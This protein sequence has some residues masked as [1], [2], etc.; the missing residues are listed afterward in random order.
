MNIETF[1]KFMTWVKQLPEGEYVYRGVSN[2]KY[3]IEASTYR[4]LKDKNGNFRYE[5]D[6]S[7][8]RLL[9]INK[10]IIEDGNRHRHG[11][12]NE[13]PLS[14]LNLL[15]ELQHRGA[16]TCLIDFTKNPLVALW[17]ACRDSSRGSVD[18]KV[19]A[20]DIQS[21]FTFKR[22]T[23]EEAQKSK[24]DLFFQRDDEEGYQLYQWQ[25][26]Y[27]NSRMRAQQSIFL[28]GG[29]WQAIKPSK[30]C[31]IKESSK[32]EIRDSLK[33]LSGITGHILFPDF[34]GF[35]E[36]HAESK[37]YYIEQV[38]AAS[39]GGVDESVDYNQN[40]SLARSY[41]ERGRQAS[42]EGNIN[43]AIRLYNSG[44][45]L[46][47]PSELLSLLYRERADAFYNIGSFE[48]AVDD[49]TM[50][51]ALNNTDKH[52][53]YWRGR[54][55]FELGMFVEAIDDFTA[56]INLDPIDERAYYWR[57]LASINLSQHQSAI[58]D[59][60]IVISRDASGTHAHYWAGVASINLGQYR[61]SIIYL[62]VA[63]TLNPSNAR[64]YYWRAFAK[65][66]LNKFES[67]NYDFQA[68]LV[69]AEEAGD[70]D[71]INAIRSERLP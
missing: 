35:A 61:R 65:K 8:E 27:Q 6:K 26:N 67:A 53:Y 10:E 71:L 62:D 4:R 55:K 22:V 63:I 48:P 11:W 41:L 28:F 60:Q 31:I 46:Q 3:Q 16:A 2:S 24:I 5:T 64:A 69:L 40:E 56:T 12:E 42:G 57:G 45:S 36:Q 43:E 33:K 30:S 39:E 29:G 20:V 17:M 1:E 18:G 50:A 49:Y 52:S 54:R 37:S 70:Q 59:F 38:D 14:D 13:Q 66:R 21:H 25:P 32:K 34:D 19:Y 47:P 9:E 51:I 58:D 7:A 15:S 44:M 68:A 23:I